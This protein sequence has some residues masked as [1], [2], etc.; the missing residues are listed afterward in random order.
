[1]KKFLRIIVLIVLWNCTSIYGIDKM[2]IEFDLYP[3]VTGGNYV[4]VYAA[5]NG[6]KYRVIRA[7]SNMPDFMLQKNIENVNLEVYAFIID[8]Y[9][10]KTDYKGLWFGIGGE[11]WNNKVDEENGAKDVNFS[12]NIFTFGGGYL[13]E[14]T[15]RIF[16]N[17]WAA[18]H[19][20]MGNERE[21]TIGNTSYEIKKVIPEAS[22]KL[23]YSF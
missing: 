18:I 9:F 6:F 15:D 4:G 19:V 1:M 17:P 20:N 3:F 16:I 13:F 2:G 11:C 21:K 7:E 5:Q 8:Y 14:L 10:D 12:Q 22:I 23:G